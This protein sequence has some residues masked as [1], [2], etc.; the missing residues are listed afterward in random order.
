MNNYEAAVA[1]YKLAIK[2]KHDYNKAYNQ[3]GML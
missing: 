1:N 2:H 3:L